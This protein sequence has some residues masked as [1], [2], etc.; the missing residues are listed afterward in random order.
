MSPEQ[1]SV[2]KSIR[3]ELECASFGWGQVNDNEVEC[4]LFQAGSDRVHLLQS[5]L[6]LLDPVLRDRF[7]NCDE[8]EA[9][10]RTIEHIKSFG[11]SSRNDVILGNAEIKEQ[12]AFW[13]KMLKALQGAKC[14]KPSS[15]KGENGRASV[16]LNTNSS[17]IKSKDLY[18]VMQMKV[19]LIPS[20]LRC[21]ASAACKKNYE[22]EL[23]EAQ[24]RLE[25]L[26]DLASNVSYDEKSF[27]DR[28]IITSEDYAEN[29]LSNFQK[30]QDC[31]AHLQETVFPAVKKQPENPIAI[32][33]GCYIE[34]LV[35]SVSA[36]VQMLKSVED[37]HQMAEALQ[38]S[39][40]EGL[41]CTDQSALQQ[42]ISKSH[43]F[44]T[45]T[46]SLWKAHNLIPN[47]N[48]FHTTINQQNPF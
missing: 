44:I 39:S 37:I 41:R 27:A 48:V 23:T 18:D 38:R 34:T 16:V 2:V 8:R 15:I 17:I 35:D 26:Q 24:A 32:T 10:T 12:V 1:A 28:S 21:G 40:L 22:K 13:K 11:L 33:L 19:K 47:T 36:F 31:Y 43:S 46:I 42:C 3:Q 9:E 5:C 45:E 29:F 4:W 7:Q 6:Y 30:I 20:E 14:P 25:E